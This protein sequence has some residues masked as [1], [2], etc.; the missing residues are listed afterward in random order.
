MNGHLWRMKEPPSNCQPTDFK[1]VLL[2]EPYVSCLPKNTIKWHDSV[3]HFCHM[4]W[5]WYKCTVPHSLWFHCP[6]YYEA[7]LG[8]FKVWVRVWLRKQSDAIKA[9]LV[10][11]EGKNTVLHVLWAVSYQL[12]K[13]NKYYSHH[14]VHNNIL[15]LI[16]ACA[17]T[18][19]WMVI[20]R[21]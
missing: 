12:F 10:L 20:N 8:Y 17:P 2:N 11:H 16:L 9:L 13:R 5:T 18:E 3:I 15:C 21:V 4:K 14:L 6:I 7:V 19:S 1:N